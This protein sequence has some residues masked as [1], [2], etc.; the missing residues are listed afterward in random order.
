MVVLTP[1][2]TVQ[3][4]AS[5]G[6]VTVSVEAARLAGTLKAMLE[7]PSEVEGAEPGVIEL[8]EL[9]LGE[10]APAV[11]YMEFKLSRQSGNGATQRFEIAGENAVAVFR[12]A[13][14]LDL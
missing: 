8:P 2:G 14:Y 5:D 3:L 7:G 4:R 9:T 11:R 13:S 10:L 12:A 6:S 1:E